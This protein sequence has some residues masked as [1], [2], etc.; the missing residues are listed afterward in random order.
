MTVKMADWSDVVRFHGHSCMGLAMGYRVSE[1]ALKALQSDRDIDEELVAIVENDS[2]AVDAVQFVTG[3][4]MGKGNLFFVDH[5]K[6]VYTFMHRNGNKAV[7]IVARGLDEEKYP[8]LTSLR[9]KISAGEATKEE[10]ENFDRL[11][12]K[13]L[14]EYLAAP[15]EETVD[16]EMVECEPPLKARIFNSIQCA[17]CGEKVMEPRARVKEGQAVCI[18]CADLYDRR[19]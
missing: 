15:L 3:C 6:P 8:E 7:R 1:T 19:D 13:A 5:G 16:F 2:C 11:M 17:S 9:K 14:Q 18:P 10:K 12:D 4:T